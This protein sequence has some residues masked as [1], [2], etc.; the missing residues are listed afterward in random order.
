M[1]GGKHGES[2]KVAK[3]EKNKTIFFFFLMKLLVKKVLQHI[4]AIC[5]FLPFRDAVPKEKG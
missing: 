2:N 4:S 5:P 3:L 1:T